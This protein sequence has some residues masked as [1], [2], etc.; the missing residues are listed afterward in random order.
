M[1]YTVLFLFV[2]L[3]ISRSSKQEN[4]IGFTIDPSIKNEVEKYIEELSEST[5]YAKDV[6]TYNNS[7]YIENYVNDNLKMTTTDFSKK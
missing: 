4:G 6:E 5:S 1:K 7:V 2:A 3:F